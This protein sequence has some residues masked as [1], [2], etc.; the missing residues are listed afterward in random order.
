VFPRFTAERE[1]EFA[2]FDLVAGG[3][4]RS[5]GA[6]VLT[7]VPAL[8]IGEEIEEGQRPRNQREHC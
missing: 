3:V 2:T 1:K 8:P 7:L 6:A 4:T 5:A